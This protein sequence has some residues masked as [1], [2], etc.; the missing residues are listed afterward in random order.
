MNSGTAR[1]PNT[2]V[3]GQRAQPAAGQHGP[4]L[5]AWRRGAAGHQPPRAREDLSGD[6]VLRRRHGQHLREAGRLPFPGTRVRLP[7]G[8]C[9][10]PAH[11]GTGPAGLQPGGQ[12]P[13]GYGRE[14]HVDGHLEQR[15]RGRQAATRS[16]GTDP[17]AAS[18][19]ASAMAPAAVTA[20][21]KARNPPGR[22]PHQAGQHD[23]RRSGTGA[24][25]AGRWCTPV[26]GPV[27]GV[28]ADEHAQPQLRRLRQGAQQHREPPWR[29][30]SAAR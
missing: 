17:S 16:S 18:P 12:H 15:S 22:A 4:L 27:Q 10:Q 9:P 26:H 7:V 20:A 1:R 6:A 5:R 13:L 29:Q 21:T 24:G 25:R 3:G 2:V 30:S 8:Q 23:L 19:A 11:R 28:L 14:R